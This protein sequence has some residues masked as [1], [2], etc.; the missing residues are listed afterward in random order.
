MHNGEGTSTYICI[1]IYTY[2]CAYT[3]ACIL[4]HAHVYIYINKEP[5]LIDDVFVYVCRDMQIY[6]RNHIH[7]QK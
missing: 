7:R 4:N 3:Y 2:T 6:R 1:Y 5:L